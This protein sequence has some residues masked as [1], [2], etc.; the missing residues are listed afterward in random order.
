MSV[1]AY[2]GRPGSGKSYGVVENVIIPCL[3]SGRTVVTNIPLKTGYLTDDYPEGKIV[4]FEPSE[5]LDNA[6]FW[7]HDRFAGAVW[8]ID[9]CWRYW[10]SGTTAKNIPNDEKQ[11]FTEH[12]HCVGPDGKTAEIVL[13]TQSLS[14]IAAFVRDLVEE[15]YRATKLSAVGA[16]KRFRID[17]F[18]GPQKML[19]GGNPHRQLLGK[20]KD[21]VFK[22]YVSHTN[23]K[24]DFAAGA[25][26]IIDDRGNIWKSPMIRYGMP[27]A[28]VFIVF[29]LYNFYGYLN[30][31]S[32]DDTKPAPVKVGPSEKPL[33]M[34]LQ[35]PVKPSDRKTLQYVQTLERMKNAE[36]MP[37]YLPLSET[38]RIVGMIN[39]AYMIWSKLGTFTVKALACD[40]LQIT[41]EPYC[42][43]NQQLVTWN[44]G[45]IPISEEPREYFTDN[46][47]LDSL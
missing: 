38:Y 45:E 39:D 26:E 29:S 37:E 8:I 5:P 47:F 32:G 22:Y 46:K 14:Q 40:F 42:V 21:D 41:K 24:T 34:P 23:N 12:R 20:Y 18:T 2:V 35:K 19:D 36:I 44:S 4:Q 33:S 28:V 30:R 15:T 27:L 31:F 7:D 25:E 6:G 17:V 10:A 16:S 3:K 9:E 1:V 43:I 11:F 13:V